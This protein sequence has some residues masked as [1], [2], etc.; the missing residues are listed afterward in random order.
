M[1]TEIIILQNLLLLDG[2]RREQ[3]LNSTDGIFTKSNVKVIIYRQVNMENTQS[4][5]ARLRN[6]I[7]RPL[8]NAKV[9]ARGKQG[10]AAEKALLM[11]KNPLKNSLFFKGIW[12]LQWH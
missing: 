11:G 8:Q 9:M 4:Q 12:L 5:T 7:T 1:D 6:I 10:E 3:I 2:G